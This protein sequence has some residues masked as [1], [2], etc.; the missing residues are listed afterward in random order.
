MDWKTRVTKWV[1]E[2]RVWR[3]NESSGTAFVTAVPTTLAAWALFNGE[4]T[5]GKYYVVLSAYAIATLMPGALTQ[6]GMVHQISNLATGTATPAADLVTSTVCV[7]LKGNEGVYGGRAIIS[8]ALAVLN[9]R[10]ATIGANRNSVVNSLEGQQVYEAHTPPIILPPGS[11]YSLEGVASATGVQGSL[12]NVWAE[13]D[14][15]EIREL[16]LDAS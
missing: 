8:L 12:G 6:W 13:V 14:A 7:N 2:G 15:K 11:I 5:E 16:G 9:D 4:P 10:W 3:A 1:H